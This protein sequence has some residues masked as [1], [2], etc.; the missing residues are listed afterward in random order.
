M[1]ILVVLGEPAAEEERAGMEV[2]MRGWIQ[3]LDG[4]IWR[5]RRYFLVDNA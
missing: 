2:G 5:I 4:M 3:V 1:I